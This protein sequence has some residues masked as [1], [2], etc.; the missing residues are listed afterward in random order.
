VAR[1]VYYNVT[2]GS[3]VSGASTITQQ[4]VRNTLLSQEERTEQTIIRKVKEAVLAVEVANRYS[5]DEILEIYLNQIYYGNLA[6][7]IE[8]ASQT[9]FGKSASQLTLA[10]SALLAG[11][12]QSPAYHD[13]YTNPEG[14]KARQEVVLGLMVEANQISQAEATAAGPPSPSRGITPCAPL[15]FRRSAAARTPFPRNARRTSRC[16]W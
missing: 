12:P 1:A 11:L 10:E 7:G 9:Y 5:K 8:A 15:R 14:A 13:P 2:E 4:L 3:I 16:G 6:Y